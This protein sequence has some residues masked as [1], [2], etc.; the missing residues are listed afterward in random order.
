MRV[1]PRSS[2]SRSASSRYGSQLRLPHSTG[3]SIPREAS[4]ASNAA[5]SSRFWSLIGLT[6]PKWR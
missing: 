1:K 6:P 3:R 4:S 2:A 5:L